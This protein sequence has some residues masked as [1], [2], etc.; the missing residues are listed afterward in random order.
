MQLSC[1]FLASYSGK[2]LSDPFRIHFVNILVLSVMFKQRIH[3]I[4][5]SVTYKKRIP[6]VLSYVIR[7]HVTYKQRTHTV[8]IAQ[9]RMRSVFVT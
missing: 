1:P 3:S 9:K 4:V 7:F 6:S 5:L 8:S 2:Q